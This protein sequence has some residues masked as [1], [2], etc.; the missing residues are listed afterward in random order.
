MMDSTTAPYDFD[1]ILETP[2]ELVAYLEACINESEGV[3]DAVIIA[4]GLEHTAR[5]KSMSQIS[6]ETGVSCE[7]PKLMVCHSRAALAFAKEIFVGKC[8]EARKAD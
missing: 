7:L 2:E 3:G 1:E 6:R 4:K 5:T 8:R